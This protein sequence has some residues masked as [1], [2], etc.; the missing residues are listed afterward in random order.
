M[1]NTWAS[2][3]ATRKSSCIKWRT[4]WLFNLWMWVTAGLMT[5]FVVTHYLKVAEAR[6][7][8]ESKNEETDV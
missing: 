6:E 7:V 5:Y 8:I 1:G 4:F 3:Q 2:F